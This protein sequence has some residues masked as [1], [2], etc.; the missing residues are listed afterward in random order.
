VSRRDDDAPLIAEAQSSEHA[1]SVVP[2]T[3]A[4][5]IAR[6]DAPRM[7]LATQSSL[8]PVSSSSE[9]VDGGPDGGSQ[10]APGGRAFAA[11][12]GQ[13]YNASITADVLIS[14]AGA[15]ALS[16][17]DTSGVAPGHLVNGSFSL[18]QPLQ[19]RR[20]IPP[21]APAARS[22]RSRATRSRC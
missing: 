21:R 5:S 3:S 12:A 10:A 4:S 16:V 15:A 9:V 20:A 17:T 19:A 6:P 11:G 18:P 14:T 1:G 13:D 8:M 2:A 7:S 22:R